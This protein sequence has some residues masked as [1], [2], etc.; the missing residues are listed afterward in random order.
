M[1]PEF[2]VFPYALQVARIQV[3]F[4]AC[5]DTQFDGWIGATLRNNLL[6]AS[7]Q[8]TCQ[9][10]SGSGSLYDRLMQLPIPR[11]HPVFEQLKGGFPKGY[12]VRFDTPPDYSPVFTLKAGESLSFSVSLIGQM[13][14]F[15][16][17]FDIS[18]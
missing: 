16:S 4:T 3:T 1:L 11:S 5:V 18:S 2:N 8:V 10:T 14:S 7:R 15:A 9:S 17:S 6:Y 12:T 13:I